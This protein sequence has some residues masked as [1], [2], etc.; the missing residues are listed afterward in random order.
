MQSASGAAQQSDRA[1]LFDLPIWKATCWNAWS[2]KVKQESIKLPS[3]AASES[4]ATVLMLLLLS[5]LGRRTMK[6]MDE[7]GDSDSDRETKDETIGSQGRDK[8]A[9]RTGE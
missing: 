4:Q 7:D 6:E 8:G 3:I 2:D 5:Q 1:R 9:N